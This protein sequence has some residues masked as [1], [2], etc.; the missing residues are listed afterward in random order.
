M[1]LVTGTALGNIELS[2][3]IYLEGAPNVYIQDYS[4]PLMYSPDSDS[5]YW[6][7]TGTTSYPVYEIGCPKDMSF[8]ENLTAND[9]LCD[10]TGVK[11]TI[12]QRN[13]IEFS[14]SFHTFFPLQVSRFLLKGGAVTENTVNHTQKFG[15]G[16]INNNLFFHVY[17]PKVYDEDTG[18]YVWIH[19][20]KCQFVDPWSITMAFGTPWAG[21]GVKLRAFADTTKPAAQIFGMFG[22]SD[23]SV[24]V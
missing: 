13:F 6:Q 15:W 22:R 4:A 2:E 3:D 8:T 12:Q 11:A 10:N 20:H 18:D 16:K 24:I 7:L 23:A 14:F 19:L 1:A 17:A 5:F 21:T 9:V